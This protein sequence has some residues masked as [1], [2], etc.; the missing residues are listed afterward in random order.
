MPVDGTP[1]PFIRGGNFAGGKLDVSGTPRAEFDDS[2]LGGA[3]PTSALTQFAR[4]TAAYLRGFQNACNTRF[5]AISIQNE[6]NFEEFYNSCTYPLSSSYIIALKAV[7]AELDKYPD[8]ASIQLMG[9]ED[10]LGGDAYAMWQLGSGSSTVHKNLQYLQNL[11][12]DPQAAAAEAFF[13]IHGYAS[14]GVSAASATPTAWGWWANGWD[15]SPAPGIP[16]NIHG[17]AFNGKKSW[18]TETSGEDPAWLAPATGYPSAGAWSL[19]LRIHQ[20]LTT[21]RQS[22][23]VYWQMTDGNAVGPSTLTSC[24]LQTNSAKYIAAKHFF[25]FVRPGAVCVDAAVT[26]STNLLASAYVDDRNSALTVVLLNTSS[27]ALSPA[28]HVPGLPVI[29]TFQSFASSASSYW[30]QSTVSVSNDTMA[31]RVLGYG[32]VTLFGAA[33]RY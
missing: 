15:A 14:D 1:W 5:T 3:G 25:R 22:A 31:V 10:L 7:R 24:I 32:I 20:A 4:C 33:S 9:P 16:S 2:L 11:A 6:L 8:L 18:M 26:G 19:G 17:F 13:C 30:Q 21:G 27:N 29:S 28:I 12:A 23:W